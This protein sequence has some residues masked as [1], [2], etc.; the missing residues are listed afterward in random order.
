[1]GILADGRVHH[2]QTGMGGGFVLF[3]DDADDLFQF[4]HQ[5]LL[6]LQPSGGVDDDDI[7]AVLPRV[8][9]GI[10]RQTRRVRPLG[11][12]DHGTARAF[13][14]DLKL[15]DGGGAEGVAG[16]QQH[17][18]ALGLELGRQLAD[19]RRLARSVDATDQKH[20]GFCSAIDGKR[21]GDGGQQ[22]RDLVGQGFA[23]LTVGH[24]LVEPPL[25]QRRSQAAR[26]GHAQIAADKNILQLVEGGLIQLA[27]DEDVGDGTADPRRASQPWVSSAIRRGCPSGCRAARR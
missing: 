8:L 6:I 1:M 26:R 2:Q 15:F 27:L 17:R 3:L 9:D 4:R 10:E 16:G 5:V 23:H 19:R 24:F 21:L 25:G 12:G 22:G 20:E 11:A 14:P 13:P 7:L 18:F